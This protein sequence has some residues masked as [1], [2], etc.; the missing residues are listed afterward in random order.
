MTG[1]PCKLHVRCAL[2]LLS[3][4]STGCPGQDNFVSHTM[5]AEDEANL[6][7]IREQKSKSDVTHPLEPLVM[8]LIK[9]YVDNQDLSE[10][11]KALYQV[12][13]QYKYST[14]T[15]KS[16]VDNLVES[17]QASFVIQGGSSFIALRPN[18]D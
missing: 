5:R 3:L 18:Y 13:I 9:G 8:S 4:V 2:F 10:K 14:A 7:R 15:G 6:E 16:N 12:R 1:C 17:V 11:I